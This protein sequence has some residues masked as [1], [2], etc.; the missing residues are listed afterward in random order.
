M[1]H[2]TNTE[3]AQTCEQS[4]LSVISIL[5]FLLNVYLVRSS[6]PLRAAG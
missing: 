6:V 4:P 3:T 2:M 1:K 5:F